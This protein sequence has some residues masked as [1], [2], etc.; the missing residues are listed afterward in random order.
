MVVSSE[1]RSSSGSESGR[2][3]L[4]NLNLLTLAATAV[5]FIILYRFDQMEFPKRKKQVRRKVMVRRRAFFPERPDSGACRERA[6][7]KILRL[8]SQG[9]AARILDARSGSMIKDTIQR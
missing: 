7:Q 3:V 4:I 1:W 5:F 6:K 8:Q 2:R 9:K